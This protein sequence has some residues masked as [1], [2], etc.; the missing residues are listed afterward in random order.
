MILI[1][2]NYHKG[3]F[4]SNFKFSNLPPLTGP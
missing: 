2:T 1:K 3:W 4:P